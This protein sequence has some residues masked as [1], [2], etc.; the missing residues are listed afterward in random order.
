MKKREIITLIASLVIITLTFVM[1]SKESNEW[2]VENITETLNEQNDE[3]EAIL[4]IYNY[5]GDI[6]NY[7]T[8]FGGDEFDP[9]VEIADYYIMVDWYLQNF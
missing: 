9:N 2:K 8:L 5:T 1:I 4:G 6:Q 7:Y 3:L